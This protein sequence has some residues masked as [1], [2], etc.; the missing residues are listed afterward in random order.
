MTET[1]APAEIGLALITP[2]PPSVEAGMMFA[3]SVQLRW[4]DTLARP[5]ATYALRSGE[6]TVDAGLLPEGDGNGSI[7][8]KLRA[9]DQVGEH[10]LTLVV[11]P[12]SEAARE[13]ALPF[14][15]NTIPHATSLAVWDVPSPQVRNARFEI[16]A[17]AKCSAL[18]DLAGKVIEIRN[19][20][21]ELM[22]TGTLGETVLPGTSA[23]Y[24]T[25]IALSAPEA[26]GLQ[27]WTASFAASELKLPHEGATSRFT[28]VTV[29]EPEHSVSVKVVNKETKE[30]IA[31]AQVRVGVHRSVTNETGAARLDVPKGTFPLVVTRVG[32][33]IPERQLTVEKDVRIRISAEKLPEED[34][35]A[36]WSG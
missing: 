7:E 31:G 13:A 27:G 4:P 10:R 6:R 30:P 16:K 28:F 11:A 14:V 8:V 22:G 2:P 24:F 20:A 32:Y 35:F 9:P 33:A 17:G 36:L 15:L 34:P 21:G 25:T 26:L 5:S 29:A 19:D 18:C 1:A 23:L 12:S 3:L